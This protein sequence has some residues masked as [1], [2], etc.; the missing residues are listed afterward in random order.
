[1]DKIRVMIAEDID[2]LREDI[3]ETVNNEEDMEIVG[4]ASDGAGIVHEA[5]NR[6]CDLILM[7]IE[8]ESSRAGIEAAEKIHELKPGIRILFLTAHET[9]DMILGAMGS[10]AQDYVVKGCP[11][12]ELLKRIRNAFA[13]KV[14]LDPRIQQTVM[15]E[16]TRLRKS[17]LSLIF[18]IENVSQ[19]TPAE[20][21]LVKLLLQEKKIQ[22]I[23]D[24]RCVEVVT[25][26][27][28]IKSLLNKFG[29]TRTREIVQIIRKMGLE[30]L[31]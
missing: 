16:Y 13:G 24:E 6:D 27:T 18:F 20:K 23:A 26:K 3:I 28:Q 17:E 19:L 14:S 31:F 10:G 7:D 9:D 8:M 12:E 25:V 29:C 1:M 15:N 2:L 4:S 30:H 21:K 11:D 22:E 5:L